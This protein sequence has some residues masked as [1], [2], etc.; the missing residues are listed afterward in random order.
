MHAYRFPDVPT[1]SPLEIK[2]ME[3]D[4]NVKLWLVDVRS[5]EEM[6]VSMIKGSIT[7]AKF[8]E[9]PPDPKDTR[10]V[11]APYCTVGRRYGGS[12]FC[13]RSVLPC[14]FSEYSSACLIYYAVSSISRS[15]K[16]GH[17]LKERGYARVYNCTGILAW[18]HEIGGDL[19]NPQGESTVHIHV[20]SR[21]FDVLPH[22]FIGV[23]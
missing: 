22:S 17:E 12:L 7:K 18:A 19:V 9:S 8:E 16:Y 23:V 21:K 20:F 1:I 6:K 15:G 14:L 5:P 13:F 2:E 11:I 10:N 3:K 4:K